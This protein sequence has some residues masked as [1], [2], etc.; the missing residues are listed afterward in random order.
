MNKSILN[1]FV[2][3]AIALPMSIGLTSCDNELLDIEQHGVVTDE[4]YSTANDDEVKQ[5]IAAVYSVIQG[6]SYQAVLGGSSYASHYSLVYTMGRMSDEDASQYLYNESSASSNYTQVWSYYYTISYWCNKIITYMPSNNVASD[7]VKTRIVAEARAI[8]AICMM[9]LVQLF[10]NP[11]LNDHLLTG[12]EG[13]TPAA[14]S[15][16]F[17][18]SELAA[19]AESLPS[20]SGPDG[21]SEIGGRLTKEACY[22]Y[23]GKAQ[24]WEKKYSEAAQTLYNKVIASGL[25]KLNDSFATLNSS[26]NDFSAENIWEF[27]FSDASSD[28]TTQEGCF[29]LACFN[30]DL[31]YYSTTYAG[32][33]MV[34]GMGAYPSQDFVDFMISHDG[35]A[36]P[37]FAATLCDYP[38]AL[39]MYQAYFTSYPYSIN[40]CQGYFR[41]KFYPLADDL[42]GQLPYFYTKRNTVYMRYAEVL[43]GYA[44]AVA[45][46][47]SA[48]AGLSGLEAL[49]MVRRRAGLSDAPSLSMDDATYGVKA[50]RRAELYDEG[51]RFIDLVRW[52]DAAT[53]LKDCGKYTYSTTINCE[54]GVYS[55]NVSSAATGGVGFQSGKDELFPIPEADVNNNPNLKQNPNW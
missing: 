35:N 38:T 45:E 3:I 39:M 48:G 40:E 37:R 18:E 29:D 26:A 28:N 51:D 44:E 21:Q 2:A 5:F 55:V 15:W 52:G 27:N 47:G 13:N 20:K 12:S 42:V 1:I 23:L 31:G 25:Y 4:K 34:F 33:L 50:E 53:A 11:P 49:N 7:E 54:N 17:I 10:G 24:L 14:D 22:A 16:A 8:R 19:A 41:T 32:L 9:N 43:L 6:D 30:A 46:G 36:S